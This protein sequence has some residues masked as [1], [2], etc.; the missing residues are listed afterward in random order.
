MLLYEKL[1]SLTDMCAGRSAAGVFYF[2][3]RGEGRQHLRAAFAF[4]PGASAAMMG[5]LVLP[6][7]MEWAWAVLA[8]IVRVCLSG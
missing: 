3:A 8:S 2:F 1:E 7:Q 5:Y 6:G 4:N